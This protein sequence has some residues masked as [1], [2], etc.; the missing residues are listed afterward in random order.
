MGA[1]SRK[2][3]DLNARNGNPSARNG[4]EAPGGR[5]S[6]ARSGRLDRLEEK[7]CVST[8]C[9][10]ARHW[11]LSSPPVAARHP[12]SQ[13]SPTSSCVNAGAVHH[14]YVVV[15]HLAGTTVQKC[16]GFSGDTIDGEDLMNQSGFEYQAQTFSFGKAVCQMDNEPAT[17][18]QV[19]PRQQAVLGALRRDQRR[20]GERRQW[21]HHGQ[22]PRQGSPWLALRAANR[23]VSRATPAWPRPAED[24]LNARAVA[25]WSASCIFIVLSTT[26][27]AYKAAVLVAALAA[28]AT[29]VGL[30]RMR[31]VLT[32]RRADRRLCGRCSTSSLRTWAP[33]CCSRSPIRFLPWV[34][35]TRSRRWRSAR[36]A[37]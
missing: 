37:A 2:P 27:P 12:T 13:A 4:T 7:S 5:L 21:L 3:G 32:G 11:L 1:A 14:A 24:T 33:P 18:P 16:V 9:G 29:G 34:A 35:R 20:V 10:P 31:G 6:A 28:L 17:Y 19:L 25:A 22:P 30:R 15:E 23:S 26:N 36:R 8:S